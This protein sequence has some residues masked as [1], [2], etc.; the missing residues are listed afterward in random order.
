MKT[1]STLLTV[2]LLTGFN[3]TGVLAQQFPNSPAQALYRQASSYVEYYYNGFDYPIKDLQKLT[4]SFQP[5]LDA[6]CKETA[7]ACS[8]EVGEKIVAKMIDG[9]KDN[10]S[11]YDAPDAYQAQLAQDRGQGAPSPRLGIHLEYQDD[12]SILVLRVREDSDAF[13]KGLKRG[14]LITAIDGKNLIDLPDD[15]FIKTVRTGEP[16]KI[17]FKRG[18]QVLEIMSKGILFEKAEL[19]SLEMR[20]DGVGVIYMP[21]FRARGFAAAKVQ[22][23]VAK[24]QSLKAKS[25]IFDLRDNSGGFITEW[26]ATASTFLEDKFCFQS[27][28]ERHAEPENYQIKNGSVFATQGEQKVIAFN[29]EKPVRWVGPLVVLVNENT[30]STPEYLANMV[31]YSKRAKIIGES[32]FG[33]GNTA[34]LPFE[35]MNGGAATITIAR[36]LRFDQTPYP[37]RATPD[38]A[39]KDDLVELANTGRDLVLLKGL[40]VLGASATATIQHITVASI[41]D[42]SGSSAIDS[43]FQQVL[44]NLEFVQNNNANLQ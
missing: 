11:G 37:E 1:R 9:L 41:P 40:E 18:V 36:S 3:L 15:A 28:V 39:V 22:E 25:I 29:F 43:V 31:Q 42:F 5:E 33:L 30:A 16:F 23:L 44:G 27:L 17:T 34:N 14:D 8:Y 24:A 4:S 10:H 32:T 26:I 2:I 20:S 21:D 6:A 7:D 38:I 13:A 19:A 12:K 35:L